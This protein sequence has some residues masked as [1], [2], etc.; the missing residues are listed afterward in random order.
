MWLSWADDNHEPHARRGRPKSWPR[1]ERFHP[2]IQRSSLGIEGSGRPIISNS[3]SAIIC[4]S[5][6][7]GRIDE[8]GKTVKHPAGAEIIEMATLAA[9]DGLM[10]GYVN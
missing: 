5:G 2:V 9:R 4:F 7:E 6:V 8:V 10:A 1:F 3:R